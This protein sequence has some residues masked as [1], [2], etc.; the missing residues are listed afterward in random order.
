[1]TNETII[2]DDLDTS[3]RLDKFLGDSFSD[4]SRSHFQKMIENGLAP[5]KAIAMGL[6]NKSFDTFERKLVSDIVDSR[7]K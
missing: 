5:K 4:V 3:C 7:L 6:T 2:Y 1:M